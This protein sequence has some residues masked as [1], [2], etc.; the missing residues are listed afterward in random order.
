MLFQDVESAEK[1]FA[2]EFVKRVINKQNR[3]LSQ[4]HG[5]D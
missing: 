5:A 2:D 4:L 3:V 1:A